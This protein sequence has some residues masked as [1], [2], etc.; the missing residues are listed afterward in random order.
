MSGTPR[1]LLVGMMGSGKTTIGRLLARRLGWRH[2]DSDAQVEAA[3]GRGVAQIFAEEG[4]AA[5]RVQEA[6]ALA[7]AVAS[8]EP[9]VVSV[10]G[11]AVLDPANRALI[12]DAGCVVWL[13][14][15]PVTLARRVGSGAGRPLLDGDPAGNLARLDAVRRP[16]Y[17]EVAE[18]AVDVDDLAPEKVV[19]MIAEWCADAVTLSGKGEAG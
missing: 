12:R 17:E 18:H 15:R 13:R 1:V 10:A 9:S 6:R 16:L 19:D 11:G 4:E 8:P 14:A 7:E 2:V 3:T 5:F